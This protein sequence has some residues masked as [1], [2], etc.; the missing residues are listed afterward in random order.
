MSLFRSGI[1]ASLRMGNSTESIFEVFVE[2][3][4]RALVERSEEVLN[5]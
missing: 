5:L 2:T 4:I 1:R 3:S